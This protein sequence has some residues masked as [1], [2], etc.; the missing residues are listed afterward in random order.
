MPTSTLVKIKKYIFNI[1]KKI[2]ILDLII[3]EEAE[4]GC[5]DKP[6]EMFHII[7]HFC[8]GRRRLHLFGRDNTIRP[9]WLT[10]GP[11]LSMSNYDSAILA[12]YYEKGL[13]TGCSER[14][15]SLR[16][17]SPPPKPGGASRGRGRGKR[18]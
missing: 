9:G 15:E 17:K 14:I 10:V 1:F 2:I 3:D 11:G 4:P 7:E 18:M 5:V 6:L 13:T 12:S 8:L 16:P